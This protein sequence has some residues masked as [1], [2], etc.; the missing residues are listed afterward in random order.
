MT[1]HPSDPAVP[2][3]LL[4]AQRASLAQQLLQLADQLATTRELAGRQEAGQIAATAAT[5]EQGFWTGLQSSQ[6]FLAAVAN[7]LVFDPEPPAAPARTSDG[8]FG[9]VAERPTDAT[10]H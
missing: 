6:V 8:L 9:D 5:Q 2:N 10:V 3:P 1:S 7:W 4:Q